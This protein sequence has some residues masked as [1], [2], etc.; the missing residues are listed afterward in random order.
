MS[1]KIL[2]LFVL[3]FN[4]HASLRVGVLSDIHMQPFYQPTVSNRKYC[5]FENKTDL[6]NDMPSYG[7][8]DVFAPLGRLFCDPPP[9]LLE[10]MLQ[11]MVL[12]EP[13]I[14]LLFVTGDFVGHKIASYKFEGDDDFHPYNP[15]LF[16]KLLKAH[17]NFT[18]YVAKYLPNTLIL[19]SFGNNDF[20]YHY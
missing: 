3:A 2:T 4:C 17:S 15:Y 11:K 10:E 6:Q 8:S 1:I 19:P 5:T 14:D 18:M 7:P 13:N 9:R 12:E 16:S 20:K